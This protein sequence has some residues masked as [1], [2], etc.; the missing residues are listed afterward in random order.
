M[1]WEH[2]ERLVDEY[3]YQNHSTLIQDIVLPSNHLML[4]DCIEWQVANNKQIFEWWCVHSPL[5][6]KLEKKGEYIIKHGLGYWWG[7]CTSGQQIIQ[8]RVIQEIA[9]ELYA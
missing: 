9:E 6:G 3:I 8:D 4:E 5:A 7:R 2:A 1:Q